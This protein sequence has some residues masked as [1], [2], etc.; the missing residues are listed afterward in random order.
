MTPI[1]FSTQIS[2]APRTGSVLPG[3]VTSLYDHVASLIARS[4]LQLRKLGDRI[5][6]LVEDVGR[7]LDLR[8]RVPWGAYT[9]E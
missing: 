6:T 2:A 8:R 9:L 5:R 4:L 7:L 1:S 3:T